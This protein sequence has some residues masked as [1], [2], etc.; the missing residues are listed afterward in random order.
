MIPALP[1]L[2]LLPTSI[3]SSTS[4]AVATA[5]PVTV[6]PVLEVSIFFESLWYNSTEPPTFA[7][8]ISWP[9]SL[10]SRMLPA[11]ACNNKLPEPFSAIYELLP[12]WYSWKSSELPIRS[13]S[14]SKK[15]TLPWNVVTPDT[16]NCLVKKVVPVTVEIPATVNNPPSGT[17]PSKVST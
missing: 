12:S 16:F 11:L 17:T 15:F 5:V 13:R 10:W 9:L 3:K 8:T 4:A 1:N 2:I 7:L 6:T 14:P